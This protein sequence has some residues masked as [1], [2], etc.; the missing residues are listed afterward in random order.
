[1]SAE[2]ITTPTPGVED[3]E[4]L[5][6]PDVPSSIDPEDLEDRSVHCH[7]QLPNVEEVKVANGRN[8]T[9]TFLFRRVPQFLR[10]AAVL[11]LVALAALGITMAVISEKSTKSYYK[12][13]LQNDYRGADYTEE[14]IQFLLEHK[15]SREPSL[16]GA[17]GDPQ[18]RA[19]QW[20]AQEDNYSRSVMHRT[21]DNTQ[22]YI[23]RF[24]MATIYFHFHGDEWN[25]KL[26]FLKGTD[27][28]NWFTNFYTAGGDKVRAGI[29]CDDDEL[30]TEIALRK[31]QTAWLLL[32]S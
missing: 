3:T 23:E 28:C 13:P 17:D 2:I 22:R 6:M 12:E 5:S 16:R 29:T 11:V 27:T 25:Y 14:V 20:L 18:Q 8:A 21:P 19:V 15:V 32:Y 1:M 24:V 10:C 9:R 30:V 7:D 31:Y 26:N 4:E